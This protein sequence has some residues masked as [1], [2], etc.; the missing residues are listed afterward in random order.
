MPDRTFTGSLTCLCFHH[1]KSIS[2]IYK[3]SNNLTIFFVQTV[4]SPIINVYE[5]LSVFLVDERFGLFLGFRE[6]D[7]NVLLVDTGH[8]STLRLN[9]KLL[10]HGVYPN[11]DL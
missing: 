6:D 3:K 10:F 8:V 1:V 5:V 11:R 2:K 4:T 9:V 7:D